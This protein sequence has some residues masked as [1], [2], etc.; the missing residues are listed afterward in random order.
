MFASYIGS[1][2]YYEARVANDPE[3]AGDDGLLDQYIG[4]YARTTHKDLHSMPVVGYNEDIW[5]DLNKNGI[6]EPEE[7]GAF[8]MANS[9]GTEFGNAGYIWI[10]Y[11]AF[12]ETSAVPPVEDV[13]PPADRDPAGLVYQKTA[14]TLTAR[15]SYT[16]AY[17]AAFSLKHAEREQVQITLG[18]GNPG[19]AQPSITRVSGTL[20]YDSS[21]TGLGG[22][23]ACDQTFF[24]DLT[25]LAS[26]APPKARWFLGVTDRKADGLAAT[27]GF[28]DV[29][30][31][32]DSGDTLIGHN[33]TAQTADG[34]QR[35]LWIDSPV[36]PVAAATE[37]ATDL[38]EN[39][40]TLNGTLSNLASGDTI[41]AAF[42]WG[43]DTE[44]GQTT[45]VQTLSA[46]G[47]F[48][49]GI[50]SLTPNTTY[51]YRAK[52]GD[53]SSI[54]YGEDVSFTTLQPPII[55]TVARNG[56][57][58][59]NPD[60]TVYTEG[61]SV[62]LTATA[63]SG[64]T[65]ASWVGA[66]SSS[67]ATATVVLSASRTVTANFS[68]YQSP[69]TYSGGGGGGGGP[70]PPTVIKLNGLSGP[71]GLITDSLGIV[72]GNVR[73][74]NEDGELI[75]EIAKG[76]VLKDSRG[77]GLKTLTAAEAEMPQ[78][79]PEGNVLL[80]EYTLGPTGSKFNP[81]LTLIL[82]YDPAS[83]PA[84]AE[85]KDLRLAC[86]EGSQWVE[87]PST[88]DTEAK[89]VSG[90]I[91]H[92][93]EYGLVIKVPAPL[94]AVYNLYEVTAS[95]VEVQPEGTVKISALVSNSGEL[96]GRYALELKI[97]EIVEDTME[98]TLEGGETREIYFQVKRSQPD[99]YF[100]TLDDT[101]HG[102]H[103]C[104]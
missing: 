56:S 94:P 46:N 20:C 73:L 93:S 31:V 88:V 71:S 43:T 99:E 80:A 90:S 75:L 61:E 12:R 32:S 25:D 30:K 21:N 6:A 59:K 77:S 63:A 4:N 36:E 1:L 38:T 82:K 40:A 101:G 66:D 7:K 89:T 48:S 34:N 58:V 60:K 103:S 11:D 104:R 33:E 78:V 2:E 98:V 57:V 55:L 28:F 52:T 97:D 45:E 8:K 50:G 54:F 22:P 72:K 5:V 87:I 27:V 100:Y 76:A 64:W 42:D 17:V 102:Q 51:H 81:G 92:F 62:Q 79:P 26:A 35:W 47:A 24:M 67:G 44:Y 91:T 49:A 3:T 18:A 96:S 68:Q 84:R 69:R 9:K 39:S 13:W 86:L 29:Y 37:A 23:V 65:F 74:Q 19:A 85:E 41:Y 53:G 16:P 70:P 14:Y 15:E 83:L 95:P 10:S